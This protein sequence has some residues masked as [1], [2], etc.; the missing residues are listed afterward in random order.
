MDFSGHYEG[1]LGDL[2][3]TVRVFSEKLLVDSF[4]PIGLFER[5]K[6]HS[7]A[8]LESADPVSRFSRYS[9]ICGRPLLEF[10]FKS[11]KLQVKAKNRDLFEFI[12]EDP[13][14]ALNLIAGLNSKFRCPS[15]GFFGG[16]VGYMCYEAFHFIEPASSAAN[17]NLQLAEA[18]FLLPEFVV[19]LDHRLCMAFVFQT[20]VELNGASIN[21]RTPNEVFSCIRDSIFGKGRGFQEAPVVPESIGRVKSSF[22]FEGFVEAVVKAKEH[23][24]EGD[25]YQIVLSQRFSYP[26]LISP[27]QLY[28][29]LRIVNPSPYMFLFETPEISLAGASPEPLLKVESGI[30]LTRPIAGTRRRGL[31]DEEDLRLE[32]ELLSDEKEI[33]EHTML[34]DLARND[35]FRVCKTSSVRLSRVFEVERYSH[36]MHIVSEV[37]G[38][39]KDGKNAVDALKSVFPAGTVVGAPKIRA[40]QIISELEPCARGPYAGAFG[41][42]NFNGDLDTCIIIRTAVF[43]KKHVHVQAG[44]GIVRDSLPENEYFETVSKAKGV[45]EALEKGVIRH[46]D[47]RR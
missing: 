23:I 11:S 31:T 10:R 33:S 5:L 37:V 1:R 47:T 42:L 30:A 19:I 34:V 24:F 46:A 28:R 18:Y 4:S 27:F 45:L 32:R 15:D 25:A 35:L 3:L 38:E 43:D 6:E 21:E 41:Y 29:Y 12:T 40:S 20:S 22:S 36:V 26:R 9:F 44:A 8:L 7:S 13:A 39:L 2:R 17:R 14:F 16:L